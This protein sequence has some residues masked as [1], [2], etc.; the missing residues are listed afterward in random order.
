MTPCHIPPQCPLLAELNL[1]L[2]SVGGSPAPAP[3][4]PPTSE[5]TPLGQSAAT[6]PPPPAS[7]GG[8]T[9]TPSGLTAV[10]ASS[11][12]LEHD[13][14]S[15]DEYHWDSDEF[16]SAYTPPSKLNGRVA[17]Y[18]PS[19]SHVCVV[20][21][22]S[23]VS[24]HSQ[25]VSTSSSSL[26]AS[27][28][29]LLTQL[30][31]SPI[32]APLTTGGLAVAD[33]G[34]TDHMLPDR[35]CFISYKS[36]VSLSVRMGNNSFVPVLGRGSAIFALNGKRILVRNML[37]VPGLAVPLHSLRTHVTQRGCGFFGTQDSGFLVYFP[38]FVLSVDT[39]VNCYVSFTPL[40]T[41]A[42][43]HALDFLQPRCA[44]STYLVTPVPAVSNATPS[45]FLPTLI[46]RVDNDDNV[47]PD[48]APSPPSRSPV[49]LSDISWQL[50]HLTSMVDNFTS[51]SP[52]LVDPPVP[53][54]SP[55]VDVS[56][57][58]PVVDD[59]SPSRLLSTMSPTE[60]ANLLYREGSLFPSVRPCDTA[61]G[62]DTKT[63]WSS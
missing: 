46:E 11:A 26:P 38:S 43:L 3:N 27:L 45:Q 9:S 32:A 58:F 33:T 44:P 41:S 62:S 30:A 1:K 51:A 48:G 15:D 31:A 60:I 5:T 19:C 18:S 50:H 47:L 28:P 23:L 53:T 39:A 2:I 54:P 14:E 34:A 25:A 17:P 29:S 20:P 35:S 52:S 61:N 49:D 12:T 21:S 42:P 16:G 55:S 4:P 7:G 56:P 6:T 13:F 37:H 63:H 22:L 40:G 24:A 57:T 59:E 8:S 36:V 10:L